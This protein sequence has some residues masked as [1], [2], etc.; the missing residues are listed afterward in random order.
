MDR[1]IAINPNDAQGLAGRGNILMWRAD[2]DAAIASLELAQRIDPEIN[3]IDRIA[4]S[5]AYY[6]KG[7]YEA[8]IEQS[9]FNLRKTEARISAM[10]CSRRAYARAK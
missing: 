1:A 4:L 5:L 9:E 6:L 7:R 3:A 2:T 8:A 10:S